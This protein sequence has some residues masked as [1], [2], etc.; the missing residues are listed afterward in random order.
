MLRHLSLA[1][2][3]LRLSTP[4]HP[5]SHLP[6]PRHC[7]QATHPLTPPRHAID[8]SS[9]RHSPPPPEPTIAPGVKHIK[10]EVTAVDDGARLDRFIKRRAPGVPPGLIQR[11]IRKRSVLVQSIPAIRNAHPVR[12]GDIVTFPGHVKLGLSRGKRRP[13][14]D[15][16]S[17]AEAAIVK[18]WVLHR[19][20]RCVVLNKPAGLATQGG[21][22]QGLRHLEALLPGIG[23]G[24][25]WLVHR[26]DKEVAGA[27]AVA[28]D[29]GA[30]GVLAEHFR[31]RL[32]RKTYWALVEGA[33]KEKTGF[34]DLPVD[35]KRARTDYRVLQK[36][37]K[38]FA[39]VEL[40]P[41]TGRKHQL[42]IHCAEGL[43]A[44]I[45]G[46]T[47][48][49]H[50]GANGIDEVGEV[51]DQGLLA[52]M[53]PGLHLFSREIQ[54]PKLTQQ[55]SG[56]RAKKSERGD[57]TVLPTVTVTAPLPPH[58]KDTWKRFGLLEQIPR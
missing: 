13:P 32:V 37:D 21:S 38:K 10:W 22:D 8:L 40:S 39:W 53:N 35:G 18:S 23:E 29:V 14:T 51:A 12:T 55:M 9:P 44:P 16:V 57:G 36:L 46:D 42:R 26:L 27:I 24:R 5:Y 41:R 28:R 45:V 33:V 2:R 31:S 1:S 15:D 50:E 6:H 20:A 47:K 25:Y 7:T 30:A 19:D 34:I 49:G 52:L 48:Y 11:L 4:S 43:G 54:F 3:R 56:K 58:M 17:L